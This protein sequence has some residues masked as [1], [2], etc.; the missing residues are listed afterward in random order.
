MYIQLIFL[1]TNYQFSKY[2]LL[3]YF[4]SYL[5]YINYL[6][7]ICITLT[8]DIIRYLLA[9]Y[10]CNSNTHTHAH[11]HTNKHTHTY[12]QMCIYIYIYICI[13]IYIYMY[14]YVCINRGFLLKCFPDKFRSYSVFKEYYFVFK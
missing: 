13:Y 4:Y 9:F 10:L 12:P 8:L 14:M 6:R 1:F 2:Y 3:I 11:T 7:I 5:L